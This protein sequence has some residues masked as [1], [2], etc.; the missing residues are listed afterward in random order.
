M[1]LSNDTTTEEKAEGVYKDGFVGE[2]KSGGTISRRVVTALVRMLNK[3]VQRP[4]LVKEATASSAVMRRNKRSDQ[5]EQVC[6][7][8]GGGGGG[9]GGVVH[10]IWNY[11]RMI[12]LR[13]G[14]MTTTAGLVRGKGMVL[15]QL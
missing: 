9:G 7:N 4:L 5:R 13:L 15:L 11:F 6:I 3:V 8:G 2:I 14:R 12:L 10:A 1:A